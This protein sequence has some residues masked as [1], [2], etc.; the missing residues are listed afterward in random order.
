[1]ITKTNGA[2]TIDEDSD[3]TVHF[4]NRRQRETPSTVCSLRVAAAGANS[5]YKLVDGGNHFYN[6]HT[7]EIV[8]II[9]QWL[10][11]FNL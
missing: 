8:E 7:A 4:Q 5:T 6:R 2:K 1:M 9:Y 10:A 11:Q 3:T